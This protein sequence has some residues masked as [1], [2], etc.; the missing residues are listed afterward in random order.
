MRA[1]ADDAQIVSRLRWLRK[2]TV[3]LSAPTTTTLETAAAKDDDTLDFLKTGFT[4][5]K[6]VLVD[7][8][9]KQM[10]YT[11][12]AIPVDSTAIPITKYPAQFAH[13]AGAAVK[14]LS[15]IDLGYIE[16]G[17]ATFSASSSTASVGAAN[18]SGRI[19]QGAPDIGD[20]SVS[21]GQ[22]AASLENIL[23]A[24]G[25]DESLLEGDGNADNVY[26]AMTHPDTMGTQK[27][28][29]YWLSAIYKGGQIFNRIILNPTPTIQ[30]N[31]AVGAKN[32]PAVYTVGCIYTHHFDWID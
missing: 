30:V 5:G 17:S 18:A 15:E 20:L 4:T 12:G 11:L 29:L 31:T 26:R 21:W 19:W 7:S 13:E 6:R 24:Y 1:A 9:T 3:P 25:I 10:M 28:Y 23:S 32:Q 14:L 27:D 8:G 16:E 22:R 2:L